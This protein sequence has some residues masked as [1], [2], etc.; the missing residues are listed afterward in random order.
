MR[1]G[2]ASDNNAGVHPAI[3]AAITNANGGHAIGYGDDSYTHEAEAAFKSIFGETCQPFFVYNGTGG[4]VVGLQAL[5]RPYEA[6]IC[7][8]SAHIYVDECGAPERF[9]GCKLLAVQTADGKLTPE[10]VRRHMH[11][12]GDVHHVQ[13]KVIS[14]TQATELGTVYTVQ[15]IRELAE[16]A[17]G[18][19]LYLHVDGARFANAAASLGVGLK[20]LSVDAGVDV[21]TFGGTKNGMMFGEAILVFDPGLA[22]AVP[23]LR[24]QAMQLASKMRYLSAQFKALLE[25]DLWLQNAQNANAMARLLAERAAQIPGVSLSQPVQAN[26]VFAVLPAKAIQKIQAEYFFYTWDEARNE[27]RWVCSFDT[28][29]QDITDFVEAIRQAVA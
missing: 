27:V 12:F 1:R 7:A 8:E 15:E 14:V 24:K 2:F 18:H 11:G 29:E 20:E 25:G 21:L 16:Y 10:L 22:K 28:T 6:V 13:V 3:L 23:F 5:L 17:H 19:G 9:T 4:N 26:A